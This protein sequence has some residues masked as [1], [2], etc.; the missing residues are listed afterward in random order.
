MF[1]RVH[2]EEWYHVFSPSELCQCIVQLSQMAPRLISGSLA[3][4]GPPGDTDNKRSLI[5]AQ[6]TGECLAVA[7]C[8]PN[9][10]ADQD[11]GLED[12]R[13]SRSLAGRT[14]SGEP[15]RSHF[16]FYFFTSNWGCPRVSSSY[17]HHHRHQRRKALVEAA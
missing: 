17:H 7:S 15:I 8:E 13:Q 4:L 10:R 6:K 9:V 12:S 5:G 2:M 3:T 14:E 1:R 16:F 11:L